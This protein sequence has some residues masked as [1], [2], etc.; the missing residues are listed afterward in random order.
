MIRVTHHNGTA[1][2]LPEDTPTVSAWGPGPENP[3]VADC[4][5]GTGLAGLAIA[6]Q[7][8][9]GRTIRYEVPATGH[10][11]RIDAGMWRWAVVE[12][13]EQEARRLRARVLTLEHEA[14]LR[15]EPG[16]IVQ[17]FRRLDVRHPAVLAA[18]DQLDASGEPLLP[19]PRDTAPPTPRERPI[20]GT[21]VLQASDL[22]RIRWPLPRTARDDNGTTDP[23]LDAAPPFPKVLVAAPADMT[24]HE[25]RAGLLVAAAERG[26]GIHKGLCG[27]PPHITIETIE[28]SIA[29]GMSDGVQITC[30]TPEVEAW[31]RNLDPKTF[32]TLCP[33]IWQ[34]MTAICPRARRGS[35]YTRVERSEIAAQHP[36]W[37]HDEILAMLWEPMSWFSRSDTMKRLRAHDREHSTPRSQQRQPLDDGMGDPRP[38]TAPI[39]VT[40]ISPLAASVRRG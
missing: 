35:A 38:E 34:P 19:H 24:P 27:E 36:D 21:T 20:V 30:R 26:L 32:S 15:E 1:A 39:D 8:Q 9:R 4:I 28:K 29:P 7:E 22:L 12:T 3:A 2:D 10:P 25:L 18:L 17:A 11:C 5:E 23:L 14:K 37:N 6:L 16:A 31:A 33:R 13:W 40:A